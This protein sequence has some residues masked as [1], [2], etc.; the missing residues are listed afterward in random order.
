MTLV[1]TLRKEI[2][3]AKGA[4]IELL[5]YWLPKSFYTNCPDFQCTLVSS[6]QERASEARKNCIPAYNVCTSVQLVFT[7]SMAYSRTST[8]A[9]VVFAVFPD[10]LPNPMAV[11]PGPT[12]VEPR[13]TPRRTGDSFR[14]L[15]GCGGNTVRLCPSCMANQ[16]LPVIPTLPW[17]SGRID[18][19]GLSLRWLRS[20]TM[21]T[22][23]AAMGSV[24][25][26][27]V[28]VRRPSYQKHL[29]PL[30]CTT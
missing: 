27:Y 8:R 24:P 18:S 15:L 1:S 16:S 4:D 29:L 19:I 3:C 5:E 23:L 14:R 21:H 11:A 20:N 2:G 7:A 17:K 26:P 13:R 28:A 25:G 9:S 6:R 12:R 10:Q 22:V 30:F